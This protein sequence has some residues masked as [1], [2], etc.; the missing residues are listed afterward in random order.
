MPNM[1]PLVKTILHKIWMLID[2]P[3]P[4]PAQKR[5]RQSKSKRKR[6][7]TPLTWPDRLQLYRRGTAMPAVIVAFLLVSQLLWYVA[8]QV[9]VYANQFAVAGLLIIGLHTERYRRLA[10]SVAILP[11]VNACVVL[12]GHQAQ[13]LQT[14]IIYVVLLALTLVYRYVFMS[15]KS[16]SS[17]RLH[18]KE[19]VYAVSLMIVVGQ[20]LGIA[21][22]G[23]LGHSDVRLMTLPIAL[24]ILFVGM[25]AITEELFFRGLVQQFAL[26]IIHAVPAIALTTIIYA[27]FCVS[28]PA[29]WG[30]GYALICSTV[31]SIVYSFRQNLILTT[32]LNVTAKLVFVWLVFSSLR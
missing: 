16:L 4:E 25:A 15:D 20:V 31:L 1:S 23:V 26:K 9:G 14:I 5:V 19:Y 10:L 27:L 11:A 6:V 8:P 12:F 7:K 13:P 18:K 29:W 17:D 30:I 21:A 24:A 32:V 28:S 2:G 3:V 22:F